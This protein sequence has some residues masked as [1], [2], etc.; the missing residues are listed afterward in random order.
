MNLI[1]SSL[2]A[3]LAFFLPIIAI[4]FGIVWLVKVVNRFEKR[5]TE[6]LELVRQ[7]VE[8]FRV[9]IERLDRIE[10]QLDSNTKRS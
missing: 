6:K 10:Q 4:V 8:Q 1:I 9:L 5:E 7:N 2:F 3:S